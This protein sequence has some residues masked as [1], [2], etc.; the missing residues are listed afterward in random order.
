MVFTRYLLLG[1]VPVWAALGCA[2][3]SIG[4]GLLSRKFIEQPF[5]LYQKRS[6]PVFRLAAAAMLVLVAAGCTVYVSKGFPDRFSPEARRIYAG[7]EDSDQ[8]RARCHGNDA[9][10]IS[11]EENCVFGDSSAAPDIAVFGDSSGAELSVALGEILR[12]QRRSMMEVTSSACPPTMGYPPERPPCIRRNREASE[13]L[14]HDSRIKTVL[15]TSNYA[16]YRGAGF[17]DGLRISMQT[18]RAAGKRVDL[19]LP[20][21]IYEFDPP[22]A[23]GWQARSGQN[24]GGFTLPREEFEKQSGDAQRMLIALAKNF[25]AGMIPVIDVLCGPSF[26]RA[27]DTGA[28]MLYMSPDHLSVTGA[29]YILLRSGI[30]F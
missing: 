23:V 1:R 7:A 22:S 21:P 28:G 29:R 3:L 5:I 26:C 20:F 10:I 18:L 16:G 15:L 27:Y 30:H 25:G 12:P 14:A 24:P 8:F 9:H 11:Y 4:L 2:I 19:L 17:T 6:W 13:A